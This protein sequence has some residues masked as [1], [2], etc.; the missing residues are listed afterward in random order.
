[1]R[2]MLRMNLKRNPF[3]WYGESNERGILMRLEYTK[4]IGRI[5][6]KDVSTFYEFEP[7]YAYVTKDGKVECDPEEGSKIYDEVEEKEERLGELNG[8]LSFACSITAAILAIV[9]FILFLVSN[10][11]FH[12]TASIAFFV[13]GSAKIMPVITKFFMRIFGNEEVRTLCRFHSAEHA[14]I[15]AYYD[16][17]RAPTMEEIKEYSIFSYYCGIPEMIKDGWIWYGLSVCVLF[18]D[19]RF[20]IAIWVFMLISFWA[21][22]VNFFFTEI[23]FLG[24][25]TEIE[26]MTAIR[27]MEEVLKHKEE[28]KEDFEYAMSEAPSL[29]TIQEI[30]EDE[31]LRNN[32]DSYKFVIT[33]PSGDTEE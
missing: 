27:A 19:L 33:K 22:K 24:I 18:P 30:E 1:M 17:G 11:Y 8:K 23:V 12:I 10:K 13:Q 28:S 25:P 31:N 5:K 2:K 3:L 29:K 21:H 7:A 32:P 4:K 14:A 9:S 16:L 26:Y 6:G 15:N 20:I